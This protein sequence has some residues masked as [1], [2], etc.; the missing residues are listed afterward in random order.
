MNLCNDTQ[1]HFDFE[2]NFVD[3]SIDGSQDFQQ[4]QLD[5]LDSSEVQNPGEVCKFFLKGSCTKGSSCPYKHSKSERAVVCKHWLRGLCKKGDSCEFLH[6]YDLS[7]MPECYF[8]SKF[9]MDCT[10]FSFILVHVLF[11]GNAVI[12]SVCI[13]TLTLKRK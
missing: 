13:S 1:L 5:L 7:K 9:G 4:L 12:L 3:D 8:Y 10:I 2:K 11:Q 6:E